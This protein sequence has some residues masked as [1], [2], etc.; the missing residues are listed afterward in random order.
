MIQLLQ[1]VGPEVPLTLVLLALLGL[2]ARVNCK[3]GLWVKAKPETLWSI[4]NPFD[5][6]V[7]NWGRTTMVARLISAEEQLY[8]MTY[9]TAMA[10]GT[11]RPFTA[12][13]RVSE[14]QEGRKLVM[15]R[16]GLEG[17]SEN[18]ELLEI[19]HELVPGP[20]GT[21]LAT[22]YLWGSRP[23]LAQLLARADLW[24]GVY[25]IKGLAETGTPDNRPYV[26]ISAGVAA[27][28]GLISVAAFGFSLG[29][30]IALVMVLA[31]LVHEFGHLLAFR[32]VGQPWGRLVF[33]PFLGA[34]AV[35]RMPFHSQGESVFAALMG[36]GFSCLLAFAC[37]IPS[38]LGWNHALMYSVIGAVTAGLNVF[39]MLPAEPLDGGIALRSVLNRLIGRYAALGLMSLGVVIA[40]LGYLLGQFV[41]VLFGGLAILANL[42]PRKID[43][44]LV[45]LSS[46]QVSIA[47]FSYIAISAA[48]Y[49]LFYRFLDQMGL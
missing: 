44:G 40:A 26:L 13:F 38:F 7:D 35:P 34:I 1:H 25:R 21:K 22:R 9:T 47:L 11:L 6:K 29:F 8:E 24:G 41:L 30:H 37:L 3:V 16:A 27:L 45:P 32:L 43:T 5:G 20:Q 19:H 31:L 10:N 23:L 39:N 14:R 18:N 36:P 33:L 12:Q 48:H 42:K 4:L 2:R 17:K 46:L 15:Q 28:T 49:T